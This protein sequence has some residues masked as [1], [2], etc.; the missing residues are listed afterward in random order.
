MSNKNIEFRI[1]K[2][3]VVAG[4]A[5]G[6]GKTTIASYILSSLTDHALLFNKKKEGLVGTGQRH[7]LQHFGGAPFES[8]EHSYDLCHSGHPWSALK[9][10]IRHEGSCPRHTE[11]DTCDDGYEPFKILTEDDVI[12]QKGKDTDRLS[13]AGASKVVWLQSDANVERAGIEAALACFDKEH[14]LLV[15][16][17][18]FLRV[19]SADMAVLVVSPIVDKI[20]RSAKLLIDKID[21]VVINVNERHTDREI[22]ECQKK[23]IALGFDVPFY[24]INPFSKENYSSQLFFDK[25][26]DILFK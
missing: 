10:T 1:M 4:T 8:I 11:C 16:G 12:R 19:R 5:S 2:T 9:I 24:V 21:F 7:V 23:M 20:K 25:L 22:K 13:S 3:I 14:N 18:S 15:E 26:Q 17:N 6:V